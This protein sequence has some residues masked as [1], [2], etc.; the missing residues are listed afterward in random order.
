MITFPLPFFLWTESNI[1]IEEPFSMNIY[2]TCT[3]KP[4][5]KFVI[6][7][8]EFKNNGIRIQETPNFNE[9]EITTA[10]KGYI[11]ESWSAGINEEEYNRREPTEE[12][13]EKLIGASGGYKE[14][15]P[16][17][18]VKGCIVYE[19][20]VEYTPYKATAFDLYPGEYLIRFNL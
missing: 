17:E 2:N 16:E 1:A 14:L 10:E 19:I 15:L 9:G 20:P 8:F 13:L 5:M 11:Y 7:F 18:S 3:A 4:G 6:I 12:E